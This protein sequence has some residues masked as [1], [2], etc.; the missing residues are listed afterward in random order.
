MSGSTV[1]YDTTE[2]NGDNDLVGP[3]DSEFMGL[4]LSRSDLNPDNK[5]FL[6]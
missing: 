6:S 1:P 2:R 4:L 3:W 5:Y